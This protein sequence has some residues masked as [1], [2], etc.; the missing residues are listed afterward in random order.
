[1]RM[2]NFRLWINVIWTFKNENCYKQF[3]SLSD[4]H[5]TNG[6]ENIIKDFGIKVV[7][8]S[9]NNLEIL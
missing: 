6:F 3:I 9:P 4:N 5:N 2:K 7:D 8:K 1:M